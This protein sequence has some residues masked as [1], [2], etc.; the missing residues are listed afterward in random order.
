MD[1]I[2]TKQEQAARIHRAL[3]VN[4]SNFYARKVD[5]TIFRAANRALWE[6]AEQ[7]GCVGEVRALLLKDDEED[8]DLRALRAVRKREL[9]GVDDDGEVTP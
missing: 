1:E 9:A 2:E 8:A 7:S 4:A 6:E 5:E 3:N